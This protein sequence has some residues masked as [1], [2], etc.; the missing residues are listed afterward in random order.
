[1]PFASALSQHPI[2]SEAIGEVAGEVLEALGD[3]PDLVLVTVTRHHAGALEDIAITLEAVLHPH[4]LVGC[5][6]ESVLST[7]AEVEDSAAISL[8][9]GRVGPVLELSVDAQR[10]ADDS[11]RFVGWPAVID[12]EPTAILLFCDPFTFPTADFLRRLDEYVPGI[13][14]IGGNASGGRGP[15]GSR[16][17]SG[18]RVTNGG[19][20]GVLLGAGAGVEVEPVVSQG[21]RPY[22]SALTVTASEGRVVYGLAG[23]PAMECLV[24]QAQRALGVADV[25]GI[26]SN[27][28]YLGRLI[29]ERIAD[30]RSGDFLVRTVVGVDRSSGAIALDDRVPLGST[31]RFCLRDAGT[32][33][34]ELAELLAG[35]QAG[36]ALTFVCTARG[37][38]LFDARHRDTST[39]ERAIGPVPVGGMFSA[40]EIGPVGGQS[41][42]LT[43][44]AT[45][46]LLHDRKV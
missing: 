25:A 27:G 33:Y 40:G 35:R 23:R 30:P 42:L 4:A 13:P 38:R 8:W 41:F 7:G 16:L 14:V 34:H 39:I 24:D 15:G 19:A 22:G 9:A 32:A 17:L 11:W 36:A 3:H 21:C 43:N 28:L 26:G 37:S 1:V 5:A 10:Q 12:I 6:A 2:A 20:V 46:A 18:R 45:L 44:S 31:V 29:D